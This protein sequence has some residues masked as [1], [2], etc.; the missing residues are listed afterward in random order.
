MSRT[1]RTERKT[2]KEQAPKA[3]TRPRM[4]EFAKEWYKDHGYTTSHAGECHRHTVTAPCEA[5]E[6]ARGY[7]EAD[8]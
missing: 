1:W 2:P 4:G 3:P 8:A 7:L 6:E 5:S